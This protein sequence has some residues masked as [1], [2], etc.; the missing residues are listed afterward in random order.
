MSETI[1]LAH[2]TSA[3]NLE[4]ILRDGLVPRGD[5]PSLWDACPSAP[6]RVYL[7][8]AYAFYFAQHS[9]GADE[10]EDL[11]V[12]EVEVPMESLLPDEDFL[13]HIT[14]PPH[15]LARSLPDLRERT[16]AL[17]DWILEEPTDVQLDL[18]E[19][20]LRYMGC[21]AHLGPIAPPCIRRL[22][23]IPADQ[24]TRIVLQEFDPVISP[25]NYRFLGPTHRAF[26]D[27]LFDR[28]PLERIPA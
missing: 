26:Q 21:A 2:G 9:A 15:E 11:L 12:V 20:S 6:D 25:A 22:A 17:R 19:G 4:A 1:L 24:V 23:K 13:G 16:L 8:D 27:S 5:H 3:T 10:A 28:F 18:T 7:S 14:G